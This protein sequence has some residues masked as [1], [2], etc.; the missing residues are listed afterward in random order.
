M[1]LSE[2]LHVSRVRRRILKKR[3]KQHFK[4]HEHCSVRALFTSVVLKAQ[5]TVE[6]SSAPAIRLRIIRFIKCIV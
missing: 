6:E 1:V 4:L 2:R 5:N 3:D